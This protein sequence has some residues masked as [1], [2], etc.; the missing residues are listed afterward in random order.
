MTWASL[1]ALEWRALF[2]QRSA[3]LAIIALVVC[4]GIAVTHGSV[5]ARS[6]RAEIA[7]LQSERARTADSLRRALGVGSPISRDTG[8]EGRAGVTNLDDYLAVVADQRPHPLQALSIGQRDVLPLQ[9]TVSGRSLFFDG[10][11]IV[12]RGSQPEIRNPEQQMHGQFDLAFVVVY[13]VP[14]VLIAT[15]YSVLADDRETGILPVLR[16]TGM[17]LMRVVGARIMVRALAVAAAIITLVVISLITVAPSAVDGTLWLGVV[18]AYIVWWAALVYACVALG[19]SAAFTASILTSIWLLAVVLWP[20]TVTALVERSYPV[21]PRAALIDVARDSV[22]GLWDWP[23]E[24]TFAP[25]WDAHPELRRDTTMARPSYAEHFVVWHDQFTAIVAPTAARFSD[26]VARRDAATRALST[27]DPALFAGQALSALARSD[28]MTQLAYE[29]SLVAFQRRRAAV[30][31][32]MTFRAEVL[33]PEVFASL[34]LWRGDTDFAGG[35]GRRLAYWCVLALLGTSVLLIAIGTR[36]I[37]G[38]FDSA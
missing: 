19:R 21:P 5:L 15:G 13:L 2:A 8:F 34:E 18:T 38:Q 32:R 26:A 24:R 36:R 11:S 1:V 25:F 30:A 6:Q 7:V 23:R 31:N 35:R 29:D 4:G 22:Y 37:A 28:L 16:A 33:T 9:R 10:S 3:H 27:I 17:P 12:F 14:L 20:A